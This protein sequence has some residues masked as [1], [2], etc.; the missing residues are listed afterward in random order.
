ML[1]KQRK[2]ADSSSLPAGMNLAVGPQ[3]IVTV[4]KIEVLL[5]RFVRWRQDHGVNGMDNAI[6][7]HNVRHRHVCAVHLD[8]VTR[9]LKPYRLALL[10][11]RLHPIVDIL[12]HHTA[13]QDM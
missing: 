11:R 6:A 7:R 8:C 12:R 3:T 5:E 1:S 10:G 4:R 13:W 9:D 2:P